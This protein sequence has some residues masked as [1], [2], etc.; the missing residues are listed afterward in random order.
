M[1]RAAPPDAVTADFAR[2]HRSACR[3]SQAGFTLLEVLVALAVTSAVLAAI[4]LVVGGNARATR[5]LEQR[6]AL[7]ETARAVEAGIPPR[8]QLEDGRLD[9]AVAGHAWRM[10][11]QPLDVGDIPAGAR[12]VPRRVLIRVRGPGG[13]L[14]ELETVRLVPTGVPAEDGGDEAADK[15]Q[16]QGGTP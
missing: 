2:H 6:A 16:G 12:W 1:S 4:G 11:V 15:A 5:A 14:V 7:I 8:D 13:G 10:D 3:G 9:G